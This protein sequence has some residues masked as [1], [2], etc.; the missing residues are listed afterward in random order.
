[1]AQGEFLNN[2][3]KRNG[4]HKFH[5]LFPEYN[6]VQITSEINVILVSHDG[7]TTDLSIVLSIVIVNTL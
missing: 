1:M 2:I 5:G 3:D 6:R 7:R 4:S